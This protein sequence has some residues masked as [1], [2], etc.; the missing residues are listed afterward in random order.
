MSIRKTVLGKPFA[1][2]ALFVTVDS[3]QRQ[4]R[5]MFDCGENTCSLLSV[6]TLQKIDHLFFSHFHLDHIA[7][8]DRFIR[9]NY[10]RID[11]PVHIW[12]PES[13]IEIIFHRLNGFTWNL[14][15][16]LPS[17]W[18]VH[19]IKPRKIVTVKLLASEAFAQKHPVAVLPFDKSILET[20]DFVVS[21][22]FLKHGI[23]VLGFMVKEKEKLNISKTAL[24][25]YH[26]PQ[27]P[28][29]LKLKDPTIPDETTIQLQGKSQ[30]I[31]F[32]RKRLLKKSSGAGLAYLTDFIFEEDRLIEWGDWLAGC[33]D[34]VCES[35]YLHCDEELAHQNFHLTAVQAARIAAKAKAKKLTLIHF[36]RRYRH[37]DLPVFL[38]E[39]R[40]VFPECEL[41]ENWSDKQ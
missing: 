29:L 25:Q 31:G 41:P 38:K 14:I 33:S 36:S 20:Q 22:R 35:Q 1:D 8:L 34:L 6:A 19:E 18:F 28:Y 11:K 4:S 32:L 12:G 9:L 5:L 23:T 2:N 26:F 17:E 13:A 24:K 15:D 37:R 16:R 7:G 3:G 30:T 39:A 27:G 40:A 10:N 21:I